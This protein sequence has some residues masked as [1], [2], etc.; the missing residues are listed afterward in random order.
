MPVKLHCFWKASAAVDF[1][2]LVGKH[3]SPST[4]KYWILPTQQSY[5]IEV[6]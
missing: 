5:D 3:Y 4:S 6:N 2:A 1:I